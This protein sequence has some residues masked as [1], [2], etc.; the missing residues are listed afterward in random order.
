MNLEPVKAYK[1]EYNKIRK[2]LFRINSNILILISKAKSIQT[3]A[4][5]LIVDWEKSCKS[6]RKGLGED[7]IR[8]AV[9]GPI[10]SGKSTFLNALFNGE[11][12][13]RGA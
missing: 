4:D 11:Y 7:I 5:N 12:L 8:I 13:K 6:L 1:I 3:S 2:D 9:V 10:K